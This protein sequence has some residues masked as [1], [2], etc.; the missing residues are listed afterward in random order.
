MNTTKVLTALFLLTLLALSSGCAHGGVSGIYNFG[1]GAIWFQMKH[2][3]PQDKAD[4][5]KVAMGRRAAR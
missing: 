2:D 3:V 1:N 4:G 5:V